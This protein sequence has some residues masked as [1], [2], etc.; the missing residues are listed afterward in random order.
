LLVAL[1]IAAFAIAGAL[2][3]CIKARDL[4]VTLDSQ[5][6]LQETARY[7]MAIVE[8]DL[9]M[10]GF[11]G[12][13]SNATA[14][15]A[16][17]AL[18]FPAKCG[19][20]SWI[21]NAPQ[22][23]DGANN[24]YLAVPNCTPTSG[25]ART[26]ADVLIVRR[27]SAQ[28]LTPQQPI[29]SAGSRNRV[30]VVSNHAGAEIFVPQDIANAIPPGYATADVTGEP[31]HADTR[32]LSVNAYYVS[33]NSS[34]AN[35]YPA[36]RRKTL[37]AGPDVSDEEIVAGIE[38][39]QVQIGVDT[40][41]DANVDLFV[42]PGGVPSG[43]IPVCVRIWLRVRAQERDNSYRDDRSVTYADRTVAGTGD[44][45]RRLLVTKTIQLRNG[46]A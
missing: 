31:P 22:F 40:D 18:T 11:W 30:L 37:V 46:G 3:A 28:R 36:L 42:N 32:V 10:A 19:G 44:A 8:A 38:D 2:T 7:A 5:A 29:V 41:A 16:N 23:V 34:A 35:G 20:A 15:T 45:F 1:A 26:G 9:R 6:R 17:A 27:A 21:T 33:A 13:T 25:G 14:V 43:A 24:G 12:L 4:Q 39:L